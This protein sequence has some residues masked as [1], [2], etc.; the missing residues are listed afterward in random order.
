VK[1]MNEESEGF[2]YLRQE[3]PK[4]REAKKKG[5][6]FVGLQITQQCEDQEFNTKFRSTDRR[7]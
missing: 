5:G 7:G 3:F 6:I 2:D 1:A 4:I